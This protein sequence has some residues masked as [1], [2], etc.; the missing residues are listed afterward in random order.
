[1]ASLILTNA[2]I[3]RLPNLMRPANTSNEIIC[4]SLSK[5]AF[6]TIL[7]KSEFT[8]YYY[9]YS[10]ILITD[11]FMYHPPSSLYNDLTP[12]EVGCLHIL[13]IPIYGMFLSGVC[14]KSVLIITSIR[15]IHKLYK[16]NI[17]II[18]YNKLKF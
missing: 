10:A 6:E 5:F 13:C 2:I 8:F 3:K 4:G 15:T 18:N 12:Y 1:M 11:L 14:M 7:L 9:T 17:H 16:K